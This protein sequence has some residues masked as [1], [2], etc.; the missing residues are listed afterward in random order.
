MSLKRRMDKLSA[1][2]TLPPPPLPV[3]RPEDVAIMQRIVDRTYADS[4]CCAKRIDLFK[5]RQ[6]EYEEREQQER[7]GAIEWGV[8]PT[9]SAASASRAW[10]RSAA[11]RARGSGRARTLRGVG[12]GSPPGNRLA[13]VTHDVFGEDQRPLL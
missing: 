6:R 10:P 3:F 2:F 12:R 9:S 13:D 5:R 4:I 8:G 7:T 11:R 1:E